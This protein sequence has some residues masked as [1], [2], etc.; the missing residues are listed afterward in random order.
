MFINKNIGMNMFQLKRRF[1]NAI[2]NYK[3][4]EERI[5]LV[6]SNEQASKTGSVFYLKGAKNNV[7]N[8]TQARLYRAKTGRPDIHEN[9]KDAK[10]V[11]DMSAT[12]FYRYEARDFKIRTERPQPGQTA[13]L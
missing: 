1:L 7:G 10:I 4:G 6:Y 13:R 11:A 3:L 2:T 12:E 8:Y 9:Y 5:L